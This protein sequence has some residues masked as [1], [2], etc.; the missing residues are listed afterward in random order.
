VLTDKL[1]AHKQCQKNEIGL[2]E[3]SPPGTWSTFFSL[4]QGM[5]IEWTEGERGGMYDL[6]DCIKAAQ[7][8]YSIWFHKIQKPPCIIYVYEGLV[9][10]FLRSTKID[11]QKVN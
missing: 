7:C 11:L 5:S 1:D 3:S 6:E 8:F 2:K 9:Y 4:L 10:I